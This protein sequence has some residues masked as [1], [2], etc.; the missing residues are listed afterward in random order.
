MPLRTHLQLWSTAPWRLLAQSRYAALLVSLHGWRL[1][2]R[3]DLNAL[4]EDE[5]AAVRD[6]MDRERALQA[7]LLASLRADPATAPTADQPTVERNSQLLWIWDF[8][9]LVV[10]L[11]WA[12][13]SARDA[14]TVDGPVDLQLT[15]TDDERRIRI[16]PWPFRAERLRVHCDGRR[17]GHRYETASALDSALA[18]ASWESVEFELVGS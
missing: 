11:G 12:P 6:Y 17:L 14:P 4:T 3:R 10:C 9:S 8:I 1:Y 2:E 13:R 15:P 5:A 16:D 18:D 7:D